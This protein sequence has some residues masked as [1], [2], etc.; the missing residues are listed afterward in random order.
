M[1]LRITALLLAAVATTSAAAET[2]PPVLSS[3]RFEQVAFTAKDLDISVRFYRDMLGLKLLFETN[4]ML[5]FDVSGTR[6]MIARDNLRPAVGRSTGI[7][8][9]HV[10]D[11]SAAHK[12]L[13]ATNAKLVG[14]EETVQT[15]SNGSLRL[16]QF[17]DPDGNM[18]AIMGF[19]PNG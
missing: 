11:F 8:Y 4:G 14:A 13:M 17:E 6:L 10:D 2:P 5:F 16:Q 7:I 19:V 18:L 1:K 3:A 15:D 12:R 9:F